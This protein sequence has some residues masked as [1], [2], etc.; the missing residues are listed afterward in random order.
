MH[1]DESRR[2][3]LAF[4]VDDFGVARNLNRPA[5]AGCTNPVA[6]HEDDRVVHGRRACAVDQACTDDGDGAAGGPRSLGRRTDPADDRR[7]HDR[8]R[9]REHD[10]QMQPR[11]HESTKARR[12][13]FGYTKKEL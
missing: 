5:S 11:K 10:P 6:L 13:N 12:R 2:E 4:G 3:D 7:E 8:R 1:V 9:R